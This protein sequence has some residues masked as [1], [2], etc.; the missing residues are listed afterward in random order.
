MNHFYVYLHKRKDTNEVFYV[1]KGAKNRA[2]STSNRNKYWHNI[3]NKAGYT[4]E[5]IS[6]N[7]NEKIAY[8]FEEVL[9]TFYRIKNLAK[10]NISSGGIGSTSGVTGRP[11]PESVKIKNSGKNSKISRK[12]I[13]ISTNIIW[14]TISEAAKANNIK[15][16]TL[17][18]YLSGKRENITNLRLLQE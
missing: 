9:I 1:G 18:R 8:Q 15:Q 12:V 3:V 14:D 6:K 2:Y 4:V 11:C 7:L 16:P 5:I 13:D 17:T 10:A